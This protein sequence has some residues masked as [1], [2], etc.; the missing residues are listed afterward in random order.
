[1]A[2]RTWLSAAHLSAAL[3]ALAWSSAYAESYPAR[4]PKLIVPFFVGGISDFIGRVVAD[5]VREP[6][7][8]SML[9]ENRPG[10]G[11]NIG[12]D[13]VAKSKADG[14]VIG[15]ATVGLAS[16]SVLQ[17]K[18]P[19]DPLKDFTPIV[20]VGSI[21]SVIVVHPSLPVKSVRDFIELARRYPEELAFG[22]SGMGT[23]S[24]LAVE[25]FKS[26]TKTR[27]LHVPYKGTAQA[28]PDLLSGRIQF[29]F[30]FP[31]T[32]I[33]PIKHGKLK[34]IAVTSLQR[35][36]ALPDVPTVGE[37]GLKGYEFGTWAG[38]LAPAGLPQAVTDKL[39]GSFMT[40]LQSPALKTK[41]S[42][43]AIDVSVKPA[44]AFAAFLRADIARWR[45]LLE[46]GQVAML[47]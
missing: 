38:I 43:Q 5:G 6:L 46:Q 26:A 14:Y 17:S 40:A 7:G 9:V 22:S 23:G 21:P 3:L 1:M 11:G 30:D 36:P 47:D 12:M 42:E 32:A 18:T 29:M 35:S 20:M 39:E 31:T 24:H 33:E 16:N 19:F 13:Y 27:M 41:F 4:A 28:V 15:L 34:G 8:S 37:S 44:Q 45:K 25:L 2:N 10:A